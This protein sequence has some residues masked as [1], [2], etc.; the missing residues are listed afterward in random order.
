MENQK[1][2]DPTRQQA[3]TLLWVNAKPALWGMA[4]FAALG[5]AIG[6]II[7]LSGTTATA[8]AVACGAIGVFSLFKQEQS[9]IERDLI[10]LRTASRVESRELAEALNSVKSQ[11]VEQDHLLARQA[12][13]LS[14]FQSMLPGAGSGSSKTWTHDIAKAATVQ[15]TDITP[16]GIANA[17]AVSQGGGVVRA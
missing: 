8:W 9:I 15:P 6:C 1:P 4:A 12:D 10:Q 17:E 3:N 2:Q 7:L 13:T 5:A 11:L 14:S 16:K